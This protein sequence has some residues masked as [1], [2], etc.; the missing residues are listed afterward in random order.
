MHKNIYIC[1]IV[2]KSVACNSQP[3]ANIEHL[4]FDIYIL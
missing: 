2:E 1:Q 4:L 3:I